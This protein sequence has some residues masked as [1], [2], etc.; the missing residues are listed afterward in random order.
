M[1]D[2]EAI[3]AAAR[4]LDGVAIRTPLIGNEE[5]DRI[6][7]GRVL[8]KAENL[9]AIGSLHD[10]GVCGQVQRQCIPRRTQQRVGVG[11]R[12]RCRGTGQEDKE[13]HAGGV[14]R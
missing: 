7:G 12:R 10:E 4:R 3:A 5:L 13:P 9:Q 11:W 14:A 1:I 2:I 8:V 6:A